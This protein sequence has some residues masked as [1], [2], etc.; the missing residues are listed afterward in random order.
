MSTAVLTNRSGSSSAADTALKAA[1][2]FWF[3]IAVTGQWI[4]AFYVAAVYGTSAARGNLLAWN[5][6]LFHG[7]TPGATLGNTAIAAHLFFAALITVAGTLQLMPRIRA[8]FPAFHRWN[9]RIYLLAAFIMGTSAL[10]LE[11]SGRRVVGDL[12]QRIGVGIMAVL[13]LAF[14]ALALRSAMARDLKTHRRW[15]LRLFLVVNGVWFYRVGM[16]LSFLVFKRPFGFDPQTF[17]GPFLT[18]LA[19]GA[20]LVPLAVL[21]LYLRTQRRPGAPRRIAMA[22]ALVVLTVAMGGGIVGATMGMWLPRIKKAADTRTS[23][24]DTLSATMTSGG[25]DGAARQYHDL[26]AAGLAT[27]NFD[28]DQLDHLGYRLLRAKRFKEAIR[29]FQLNVEAYPHSSNAYD[30]LG[31]AFMDDGDRPQAIAKYQRALQLDPKSRNA[32]KM[33]QK[34]TAPE[35]AAVRRR[36][37]GPA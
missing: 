2:G 22:A 16:M 31:E 13:I 32:A 37:P 9:G 17:T 34:L 3:L 6:T 24:A 12:S 14:A 19:F 23:I 10:Y 7:Y 35:A 11:F 29:I 20:Y 21:E 18:F 4:F 15:A 5:K 27:Y 28:E 30:S 33:L 36:S 25:I 1:A 26:K 8:R